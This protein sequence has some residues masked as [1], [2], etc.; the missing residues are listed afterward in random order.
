MIEIILIAIVLF[1][2][3]TFFYKQ[4][5]CEFRIN[6]VEWSQKENVAPLLHEKVPLVLRNI[7]P[8]TFWT[9]AD[10]MERSCFADLP[11]FQETG[12][13]EW[14]EKADGNTLCPWKHTQAEL[15][16]SASGMAIWA[17]KWMHP[18][19]M[20]PLLRFWMFA[21]YHCWAGK[22]GLRKTFATWTCIFPV[23]GE[24]M[25]SILPETAETALPV[26]W[27]GCFPS[28]LTAKETPFVADLKYIDIILRPGTCLFM[29]AHWFVSWS[30]IGET[31]PMVCTISYHTPI[32]L[33]AFHASPFTS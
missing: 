8:A 11:I 29:P 31:L 2:I 27:V 9:Y 18:I 30:T 4:A 28:E 19:V 24:I 12:L 32:S 13:T 21:R 25:V 23:D 20:N 10:V 6:Q 7:P 3:L 14:L 33:L 26:P 5:I 22:V 15:I 17:K 1:L 16:A